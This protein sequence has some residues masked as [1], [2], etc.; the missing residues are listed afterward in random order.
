MWL[1]S[2]FVEQ[3]VLSTQSSVL[4][5]MET[6]QTEEPRS[7]EQP[8]LEVVIPDG[9]IPRYERDAPL[10]YAGDGSEAPIPVET[11]VGQSQ[12]VKSVKDAPRTICGFRR[13]YFWIAVVVA[14]AV[15][16]TAV[17]V[18]ASFAKKDSGTSTPTST[19]SAAS[20]ST[21]A[22]SSATSSATS[23]PTKGTTIT[24]Q[25]KDYIRLCDTDLCSDTGGCASVTISD[26]DLVNFKTNSL[27]QCIQ[28]CV[29]YNT[30]IKGAP[31]KGVSWDETAPSS[32]N[33]THRC[34]LK[35]DTS[36]RKTAPSGWTILSA[37]AKE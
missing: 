8:G 26:D 4:P 13:L 3:N 36:I 17:G 32:T 19:A 11:E 34:F 28:R 33:R 20:T 1:T 24:V 37:V 21:S 15:I 6:K 29:S 35:N 16:A 2:I 23:C 22:S 27:E 31:C 14:V 30:M 18:G 25:Q 9:L 10:Y 7:P 5:Q 12:E